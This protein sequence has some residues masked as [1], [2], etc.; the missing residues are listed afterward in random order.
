MNGK[1]ATFGA[2]VAAVLCGDTAQAGEKEPTAI[3]AIGPAWEWSLPSQTMRAG[4]S[5]SVEFSLI[6][7]WLELEVGA[8]TLFR[9]GQPEW[10]ADVLFKKPFTLSETAELML[11]AGP[12]WS[13][14]K[15]AT[16]QTGI[17]F[18]ADFM[19]WP[20]PERKF[21]WFLAQLIPILS[22]RNMK[23]LLQ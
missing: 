3:V 5:A 8:G 9:K 14:S 12:S 11:G 20:W 16:G 22:P 18:V 23:R 10:E 19:F 1:S 2:V 15:G 21:G 6:K 17:T 4:P 7:D 13:Y